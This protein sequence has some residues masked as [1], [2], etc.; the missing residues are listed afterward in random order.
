MTALL[1]ARAPARSPNEAARHFRE[2]VS[3][4]ND[5]RHIAQVAA[6]L[7]RHELSR[8]VIS[9][10]SVEGASELV[11]AG[12]APRGASRSPKGSRRTADRGVLNAVLRSRTVERSLNHYVE[13]DF[14]LSQPGETR[15]ALAVPVLAGA[16]LV[17]VIH[18]EYSV[19]H[20]PS[21]SD[22]LVT[23]AVAAQLAGA[24]ASSGVAAPASNADPRLAR[25]LRESAILSEISTQLAQAEDPAG[26]F[27]KVTASAHEVIGC[28]GA[29]LMMRHRSRQMLDV[30]ASSGRIQL[31]LETLVPIDGTRVGAVSRN[32]TPLEIPAVGATGDPILPFGL[33][34]PHPRDGLIV[35]V[36]SGGKTCGVLLVVDCAASSGFTPEDVQLLQAL[37]D[38]AG[39]AEAIR[40]IPPLRQRISDASLIAEV[41]RAMTGT[42]GLDDVLSLIVKAAE[43]LVSG[44]CATVG[45]FSDDRSSLILAAASGSLMGKQGTVLP[46]RETVMGR[47]ALDGECLI[48]DSLGT[49]P[50]GWPLGENFGPA[51]LVPLEAHGQIRG[52]LLV[53]R[54]V[55]AAIPSDE[56]L[57]A[58][59][60]LGAYAAIALDNARLYTQQT[61]LTRT[62]Q[63]QAKELEKAYAELN[64]S[65]ERLLVSEKM[66]ALGRVTAGIAHEINSPLGSILNCLQLATTYAQEYRESAD[67]PEVTPQDH[68]GIATDLL[69]ALT[70]AEE[71]TRR[72]AQ[73]VRTIKGQTRM[74]EERV[75]PFDPAEEIDS[76]MTLLRHELDEGRIEL[77]AKLDEGVT[78][79]GD[80]SKFAVIVQNLIS[81]AIDAYEGGS[82]VVRIRLM[83]EQ[84]RV[85]LEVEDEGSGI[86]EEIRP[87]IFD[88]LFT[89]KDVGRGTGLGLSLVHNIV[90]S[91]FKGTIDYRSKIGSGTTFVISIP[92]V[93]EK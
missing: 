92:P 93:I 37:A 16:K 51:A 4:W 32:G 82:G 36:T 50:R 13:P 47:V 2:Q 7:L 56:D 27:T 46:A 41:G 78:L 83:N 89:T 90:T 86:P 71:A 40:S 49:D 79:H 77:E 61:E 38:A 20:T 21:L 10:F 72:V 42:L 65:Q 17:G 81:N 15:S 25:K 75:L 62:L 45:L 58:L 23:E 11:L 76:T 60:K 18:L 55:G 31:P 26:T 91:H 63:A 59:R 54:A 70:L 9:I 84:D 34:D 53:A 29:L 8:P 85:V 12:T 19:P 14:I 3:D 43:M 33:L 39:A 73:F 74:D 66:A 80:S 5:A 35:P 1:E 87:R 6:D 22:E 57:D 67:D 48:S 44:R 68:I 30:V 52:V 28:G 24:W 69:E 64:T 88:Y